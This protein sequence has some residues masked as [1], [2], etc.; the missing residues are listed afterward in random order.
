MSNFYIYSALLIALSLLFVVIPLL[1]KAKLN[2]LQVSN[3]NV[4]KQRIL[5]LDQEVVEGLIS[6]KDKVSSVKELKLALVE[7]SE[8][9]E[10][11]T[12]SATGKV[13]WL[14]VLGLSL[15]AI[16][17]GAWVYNNAN[18]L[19]GLQQYIAAQSQADDLTARIQGQS[20]AQVTPNDY[21]KFAL[22]IRKRLRETPNDVEGWQLLGQV[23]MAIGRMEESIAAFEKALDIQPRSL[24]IREKYA[25]ALMATGSEES[26]QNAKRQVEFLLSVAPDN[27][28]YRL[29]LTV[30]ATQLGD[31]EVALTNFMMV[32]NELSAS[33]NFYQS[34]VAQLINIGVPADVLDVDGLD[35][36]QSGMVSIPVSNTQ[37][38]IAQEKDLAQSKALEVTIDIDPQVASS[39]P[40]SGFLIVFAQNAELDSRVPLA[41]SRRP[42]STFPVTVNLSDENAMMPNMTLSSANS[43]RLTARVSQD[44]DVMPSAGE[45]QGQL[46]ELDLVQGQTIQVNLVVNKELQ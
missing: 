2:R 28:D 21:A 15:P 46:D 32:R 24:D 29:L 1:R 36:D 35:A 7:E 18:Q 25:Q 43:I 40:A 14:L 23:H 8:L 31:T 34:L 6:E 17:L 27:R 20:S 37:S 4:V 9:I 5:E 45:L 16:L 42:L 3:A 38:D 12:V 26:L 13:N 11:S 19:D 30:V 41:V 22:L 10:D 33:S 44:A 39:L